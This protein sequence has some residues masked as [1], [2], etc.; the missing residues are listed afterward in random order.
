MKK[1]VIIASVALVASAAV[2]QESKPM[3][4]SL[5]VGMFWPS[6]QNAKTKAGKSWIGGGV[7]YKLSNMKSTK[8]GGMNGDLS[9]S[10]DLYQKKG[11][12]STPVLLNWTG[13]SMEG[14]YYFGGVGFS[15]VKY[16]NTLNVKKSQTTFA[17]QA[18]L[19]YDFSKGSM[20]L[21]VEAKYIGSSQSAVNGFG[22]F[23]G[24]RF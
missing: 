8:V 12:R 4:L 13:H 3:G 15:S 11:F 24:I 7:E 17:Y 9:V 2:A 18:G 22:V 19:G 5:R 21:F 23:V 16:V 14:F 6:M 20:P 10:V 1:A